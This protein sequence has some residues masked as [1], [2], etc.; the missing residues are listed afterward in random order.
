[1]D[2]ENIAPGSGLGQ[3]R[4]TSDQRERNILGSKTLDKKHGTSQL[5]G[6]FPPKDMAKF[7]GTSDSRAQKK[8]VDLKASTTTVSTRRKALGDIT[9]RG[10]ERRTGT[11]QAS[12]KPN[13]EKLS[14]ADKDIS[15]ERKKVEKPKRFNPPP[16]VRMQD[17][18]HSYPRDADGNEIFPKLPPVSSF[19]EDLSQYYPSIPRD[20][21]GD[22]LPIQPLMRDPNP[23][24]REFDDTIIVASPVREGRDGYTE[25]REKAIED[26]LI[27]PPPEPI[28]MEEINRELKEI[29]LELFGDPIRHE[30][31]TWTEAD[32]DESLG[33]DEF[34]RI[35][36]ESCRSK[37]NAED[38]W[39]DDDEF[40]LADDCLETDRE[41]LSR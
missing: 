20:K 24:E 37:Y 32:R 2:A 1:M 30:N 6:L 15:S 40:V 17:P 28:P 21:N 9:N 39:L 25:A 26:G 35:F 5:R 19:Y 33:V 7:G 13:V 16:K 29:E 34:T 10:Q 11:A 14:L 36:E 8:R 4:L 22:V 31:V 23:S 12:T 27:E 18:R 3:S 38:A 41:V